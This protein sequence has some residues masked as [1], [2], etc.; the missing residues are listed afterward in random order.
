M[1]MMKEWRKVD[2]HEEKL[3]KILWD[4]MEVPMEIP[5]CDLILGC[6]SRNTS[7]AVEC[8]R[9]WKQGYGDSIL[10]TGGYGKITKYVFAKP[11]AQVFKEL[12]I[13][14]GVPSEKIEMET[15]SQ[16][17]GDNFRFSNKLIE[18]KKIKADSIL[19]VCS[20]RDQKRMYGSAKKHLAKSKI[21]I[22][23]PEISFEQY[24]TD[25]EQATSIDK[26]NNISVLV[27]DI[28]RM[29]IF[30]QFGWQI[31]E[32]VPEEVISAYQ[33]LKKL[34]YDKYIISKEEIQNFMD[35]YGIEEG[36]EPIYFR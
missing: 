32:K 31:E 21:Y 15:K 29:I 24:I 6:G 7:I 3:L 18:T 14:E 26:I 4:Y 20:R 8:A 23:S 11:E 16:N 5:K 27:G 19:V 33:E 35:Q 28:Q 1:N 25:L 22:T 34:G 30:P 10:F 13:Q 17:T 2:I 9:L 12:A 36:K